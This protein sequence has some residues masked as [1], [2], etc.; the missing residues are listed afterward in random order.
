MHFILKFKKSAVLKSFNLRHLW[1]RFSYLKDKIILLGYLFARKLKTVLCG[2]RISDVTVAKKPLGIWYKFP[3]RF[4]PVR[5]PSMSRSRTLY[6]SNHTRPRNPRSV[7]HFF[8]RTNHL[9]KPSAYNNPPTAQSTVHSPSTH[10]T[11]I[12]QS[13]HRSFFIFFLPVFICV[14]LRKRKTKR[15]ADNLPFSHLIAVSSVKTYRSF[16][17]FFPIFLHIRRLYTQ[18]SITAHYRIP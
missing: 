10:L 3:I 6:V 1:C 16:P 14:Y 7:P 5:I 13:V 18:T 8:L 15:N 9:R 11:I 12:S 2:Y 17:Y 4:R